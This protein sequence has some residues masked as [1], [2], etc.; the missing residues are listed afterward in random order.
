VPQALRL[1]GPPFIQHLHHAGERHIAGLVIG[2]WELTIG[3]TPGSGTHAG[4][5]SRCSAALRRSISS[6]VIACRCAAGPMER[7]LPHAQMTR[8]HRCLDP[9][10]V[11]AVRC[12]A[13]LA[14][15]FARCVSGRGRRGDRSVRLR[16][17]HAAALHQPA[18]KPS[19][20]VKCGWTASPSAISLR[21]MASDGACRNARSPRHAPAIGMALPELQ[22]VPAHDG[23]AQR[24]GG[25]GSHHE[26]CTR[27]SGG[28]TA[29]SLLKPCRIERQS[30]MLIR[31]SYP[32][33]SSKRVASRARCRWNRRCM[34]STRL[35][36]G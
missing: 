35:H 25:A 24:H 26:S 36:P 7:R 17:D 9:R 29:M 18:W 5:R 22:P 11:Q 13:G 16:Q 14:Q 23:A 2:L 1:A 12:D 4:G 21:P 28:A 10:P 20:A 31:V 30:W 34:L 15:C 3:G 27:R 32:A 6:S 33:V 8:R 19:R